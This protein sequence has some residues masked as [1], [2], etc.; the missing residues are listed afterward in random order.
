MKRIISLILA[1]LLFVAMMLSFSACGKSENTTASEKDEAVSEEIATIQKGETYDIGNNKIGTQQT[2][3]KIGK[4]LYSDARASVYPVIYALKDGGLKADIADYDH[5]KDQTVFVDYSPDTNTFKAEIEIRYYC[6]LGGKKTWQS[7][8][9][10]Y[11]GQLDGEDIIITSVSTD[12]WF[13]K[14]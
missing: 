1:L 3:D 13:F 12:E 10:N 5:V 6:E 9:Y 8:F 11:E 14:Q 4:Y 7:E 2:I